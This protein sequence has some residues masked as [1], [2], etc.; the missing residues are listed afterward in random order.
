MSKRGIAQRI[1]AGPVLG[2]G[3]CGPPRGREVR[4]VTL[5]AA[6]RIAAAAWTGY[7]ATRRADAETQRSARLRFDA[8]QWAV[9]RLGRRS[10]SSGRARDLYRRAGNAKTGSNTRK[11]KALIG[12]TIGVL[13]FCV[14]CGREHDA[15]R[16]R[17]LPSGNRASKCRESER[18]PERGSIVHWTNG[19]DGECVDAVVLGHLAD[20]WAE[21]EVEHKGGSVP[22]RRVSLKGAR[23]DGWH[24]ECGAF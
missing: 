19:P 9:E 23:F 7:E 5:R 14:G 10:R 15:S 24:G 6:R 8:A 18:L 16:F 22:V 17:R 21:L 1:K 12:K 2:R 13:A 3:E 11:T 20:G 4:A